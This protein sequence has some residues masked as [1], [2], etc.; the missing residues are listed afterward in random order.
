MTSEAK[1]DQ[2]FIQTVLCL[3]PVLS[4][5]NTA[6]RAALDCIALHCTALQSMAWKRVQCSAV[7]CVLGLLLAVG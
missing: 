6:A 3:A 1:L 7:K 4:S 2:N 5:R